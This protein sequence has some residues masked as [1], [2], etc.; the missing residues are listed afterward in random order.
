MLTAFG[1][2]PKQIKTALEKSKNDASAFI[3]DLLQPS[4]SE[5]NHL[6]LALIDRYGKDMFINNIAKI[7]H[8]TKRAWNRL[9]KN[10]VI[11][12]LQE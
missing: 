11:S 8:S 1:L 7:I 2:F 3:T 10:T 9:T 12:M 4:E 6:T 5:Q